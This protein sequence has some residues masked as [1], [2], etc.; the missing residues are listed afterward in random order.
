[1]EVGNTDAEGRLVLCDLLAEAT[2]DKPDLLIDCATLTGAARVALGPDIPAL[3][4]NDERWAEELLHAGRDTGDPLW[5]LPLW[6]GYDPWLRSQVADIN[7]VSTKPFAGAIIG[8]LFLQRFVTRSLPWAHIDLY[9]WNDQTMPAR[10][11]GGE[12]QAMRAV[13]AAIAARF[14]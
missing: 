3:F 2:G 7:N 12:A 4:C 13:F 14:G 1:V 11:E 6:D 5:R 9:A 8:A 10:P